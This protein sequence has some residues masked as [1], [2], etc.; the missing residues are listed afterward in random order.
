MMS[1]SDALS[2]QEDGSVF[3]ATALL[4][5]LLS[6][7]IAVLVV[8]CLPTWA[9]LCITFT[10]VL[11]VAIGGGALLAKA[12][13]TGVLAAAVFWLLRRHLQRRA[14]KRDPADVKLAAIPAAD[15]KPQARQPQRER[16]AA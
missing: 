16:K 4:T 2:P 14:I 13:V 9:S 8:L 10:A 12:A 7:M 15:T 5:V 3:S 6:L 1:A 11:C